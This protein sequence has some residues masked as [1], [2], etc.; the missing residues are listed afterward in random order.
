MR[1]TVVGSGTA[2]LRLRR[3]HSCVVVET[4]AEVLV[5]DLGF[6]AVRGLRRAGV[7]PVEVDR[8]FLTHFHGDHTADLIPFLLH[9]RFG[10]RSGDKTPVRGSLTVTGPE[11]FPGFWRSSVR[12]LNGEAPEVLALP[13]AAEKGAEVPLKLP[14]ASLSWAPAKHRPESIAYRLESGGRTLVITGDTE[15]AESVVALS[16]G[17]HAAL[18][19]CSFPD[20]RPVPGHLTPHGVARL[21]SEAGVERVVLTHIG[22]QAERLDLAREV[23]R[24]YSGEVL[25]AED[26]LRFE[27]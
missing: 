16:R 3:R 24:G 23:A 27:V 9:R 21:A 18:V 12:S 22:P 7:H 5:F 4:G 13:S 15:Y 6:R 17:A 26:G 14:G 19:D 25:V 2:S 20:E 11:P 8:V 10:R 1:V